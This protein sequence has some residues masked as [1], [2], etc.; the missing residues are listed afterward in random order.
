MNSLNKEQEEYSSNDEK[1]R[2]S[3]NNIDDK[4]DLDEN[5]NETLVEKNGKVS[6]C[7]IE[8]LVEEDNEIPDSML[9]FYN[10]E[11]EYIGFGGGF[12]FSDKLCG[13]NGACS[14]S[15]ITKNYSRLCY[16]TLWR[17]LPQNIPVRE[18]ALSRSHI[19]VLLNNGHVYVALNELNDS[20]NVNISCNT[21][22][23]KKR[24]GINS[25]LNDHINDANEQRNSVN[26]GNTLLL[27][28][29]ISNNNWLHIKEL[30]DKNIRGIKIASFV[31]SYNI[32]EYKKDNKSFVLG[33]LSV[34]GRIWVV[35]Y[36]S[37]TQ[38]TNLRYLD[39]GISG[40]E[41]Y[42][43]LN[44]NYK[45]IRAIDITFSEIRP[46]NDDEITS[47]DDYD[48]I[49]KFPNSYG[50]AITCVLGDNGNNCIV[51]KN[52]LEMLK[53]DIILLNRPIILDLPYVCRKIFCG[54]DM[55][56]GLILLQNGTL[57]SWELDDKM[58][59]K[60]DNEMPNSPVL[61]LPI[62]ARQIDQNDGNSYNNDNCILVGN[63]S[64]DNFKSSIKLRRVSG[65]L[66]GKK[67]I[68]FSGLNGEFVALTNDGLISEWNSKKRKTFFTRPL[69]ED[70]VIFTPKS[71]YEIIKIMKNNDSFPFIGSNQAFHCR[72][73][74]NDMGDS[75]TPNHSQLDKENLS[76]NSVEQRLGDLIQTEIKEMYDSNN[77][78][79]GVWLLE[80]ITLIL[81]K[82]STLKA[83]Y[84]Y[85][86]RD[87]YNTKIGL[88]LDDD[89]TN[90]GKQVSSII[91]CIQWS[92]KLGKCIPANPIALVGL[93]S[94]FSEY[95]SL[96]ERTKQLSIQRSLVKLSLRERPVYRIIACY[97]AIIFGILRSTPKWR[98]SRNSLGGSSKSKSNYNEGNAVSQSMAQNTVNVFPD[99]DKK[100][101]KN[102]SE[103][104]T[105]NEAESLIEQ[106]QGKK[107]SPLKKQKD[108]QNQKKIDQN[109]KKIEV[110]VDAELDEKNE[111]SFKKLDTNDNEIESKHNTI[112][113]I[114]ATEKTHFIDTSNSCTKN[115]KPEKKLARKS[116]T[117]LYENSHKTPSKN[118]TVLTSSSNAI[119]NVYLSSTDSS[120]ISLLP[121][122][123]TIPTCSEKRE[124]ETIID[125]NKTEC[126]KNKTSI[127]CSRKRSTAK[128]GLNVS[129]KTSDS[130]AKKRERESFNS[131][132]N[133]NANPNISTGRSDVKEES[134]RVLN[135]E[136]KD[137]GS[138]TWEPK[139]ISLIEYEVEQILSIREKPL[140]KQKEYL[141]KWKVPGHP[142]QPTWE[143]EE[144]L[145]G[146]EELLKEFLR[147]IKTSR[148]GRLL[149]PCTHTH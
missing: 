5:I 53:S 18:L 6:I 113:Y 11:E 31:S 97:D 30:N 127:T 100:E 98:Q 60:S 84:N 40:N 135:D 39:V 47:F 55:E 41:G 17:K 124:N 28:N 114:N 112:D 25:S 66:S 93:L 145:S 144:N 57:W 21:N 149:L 8:L 126:K 38:N 106:S 95:K 46:L 136:N 132:L 59:D 137:G 56:Y 110:E 4:N 140:T 85:I 75:N 122:P 12:C 107:S 1:K 74:R 61:R 102:G 99:G 109:K 15:S 70:P 13:S 37:I 7:N 3:S 34:D 23:V 83:V 117:K 36:N 81:H 108:K 115:I 94:N 73:Q 67:V 138:P 89:K 118:N 71:H 129:K 51:L 128:S 105:T 80:G 148:S 29:C 19:A 121:S 133:E 86:G 82:D 64:H 123:S 2:M 101:N 78:I 49:N 32:F 62:S 139:K 24:E 27:E 63:L 120:F 44:T 10:I 142:V 69:I 141:I 146:C 14:Y 125:K 20:N 77:K 103:N 88:V 131:E 16:T 91:N 50:M 90:G 35:E 96:P 54:I 42:N 119:N 134:N 116:I 68:D 87:G 43:K 92:Y 9:H 72:I 143:P 111:K 45:L 22:D 130:K 76:L 33:S 58:I 104:E 48:E 52:N 65:S 79:I 147:S 26:S